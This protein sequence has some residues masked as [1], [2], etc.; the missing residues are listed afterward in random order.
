MDGKNRFRK[1]KREQNST[2]ETTNTSKLDQTRRDST[3]M[4]K[5]QNETAL[6]LQKSKATL[7]TLS[8]RCNPKKDRD[9]NTSV[10]PGGLAV[11]LGTTK[12]VSKR[13]KA[14]EARL[15]SLGTGSSPFICF[16]A[17]SSIN[18][19]HHSKSRPKKATAAQSK[20]KLALYLLWG[21]CKGH[22]WAMETMMHKKA[23][24]GPW[25]ATQHKGK[26]V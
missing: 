19:G 6:S 21:S 18:S 25:H 22:S 20:L 13:D 14:Q 1:L 17:K 12:A 26:Q 16:G 8:Q 15:A 2:N 3:T 4:T 11:P 9:A 5:E 10:D 7:Y 23:S 24:Q